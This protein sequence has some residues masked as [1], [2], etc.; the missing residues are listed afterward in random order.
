MFQLERKCGLGAGRVLWQQL[1]KERELL[2]HRQVEEEREELGKMV[3]KAKKELVAAIQL[4]L[5]EAREQMQDEEEFVV[6]K[7]DKILYK[8]L[9]GKHISSR[10]DLRE[11]ECPVC[12]TEMLP[13]IRI[14]QVCSNQIISGSTRQCNSQKF[15]LSIIYLCISLQCSNGHALCQRCKRNPNINR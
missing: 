14:W 6:C 15:E 2:V 1:S 8:L 9:D 7:Y 13:P 5:E 11:L 4:Q 12:L 10:F 3:V